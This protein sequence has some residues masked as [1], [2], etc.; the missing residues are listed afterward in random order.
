MSS[1]VF[2]LTMRSR[3]LEAC[4]ISAPWIVDSSVG[5]VSLPPSASP[6]FL[7]ASPPLP[8]FFCLRSASRFRSWSSMY[9]SNMSHCVAWPAYSTDGGG[10]VIVPRSLCPLFRVCDVRSEKLN[11]LRIPRA[12]SSKTSFPSTCC[13]SSSAPIAFFSSCSRSFCFFASSPATCRRMPSCFK[14]NSD[15]STVAM[16]LKIFS[17]WEKWAILCAAL[18]FSAFHNRVSSSPSSFSERLIWSVGRIIIL[19]GSQLLPGMMVWRRSSGEGEATSGSGTETGALTFLG[20]I[21]PPPAAAQPAAGTRRRARVQ[22][23]DPEMETGHFE[24]KT[25]L[26]L[27]GSV[28]R[29]RERQHM[30]LYGRDRDLVPRR[31]LQP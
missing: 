25:T 17:L 1:Y 19:A 5:T 27:L 12:S 4:A 14:W 8:L 15:C 13:L 28:R 30:H 22:R 9:A 29:P 6:P 23:R 20:G 2:W 26:L 10:S 11:W 16:C 21:H 18:G 3:I 24:N 31:V 7:S